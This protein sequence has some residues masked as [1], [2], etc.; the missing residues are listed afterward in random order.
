MMQ[1]DSM[2][3][4]LRMTRRNALKVAASAAALPPVHI[5]TAGAAGSLTGA[6]VSH[7]VPA[8]DDALRRLVDEWGERT[9][10]QVRI[11]FI[12]NAAIEASEAEEA[13]A[14][15]G[16]DF[17]S[18]LGSSLKM[19][20]YAAQ[21]EPMDDLIQLLS[22]NMARW[23]RCWNTWERWRDRGLACQAAQPQMPFRVA[24][25][26]TCSSGTWE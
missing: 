18:F 16:H 3:Q 21:L 5:R 13:Q 2:A 10:T 8:Y 17:R 22:A 23:R 9:K 24:R 19:H 15:T 4:L 26:S 12:S 6:A 11:D 25:G 7:F 14:R 20:T 1:G